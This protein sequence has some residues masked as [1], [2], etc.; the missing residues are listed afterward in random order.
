MPATSSDLRYP[1]SPDARTH[2]AELWQGPRLSSP[3][4]SRLLSTEEDPHVYSMYDSTEQQDLRIS[5][6]PDSQRSDGSVISKHVNAGLASIPLTC[7]K[8]FVIAHGPTARHASSK[9]GYRSC[10]G[11]AVNKKRA[12]ALSATSRRILERTDSAAISRLSCRQTPTKLSEAT[13]DTLSGA[14]S[15][16]TSTS[17][18]TRKPY[19][20]TVDDPQAFPVKSGD[21]A[22]PSIPSASS[23]R[24]RLSKGS[25]VEFLSA[26][27]GTE[28]DS[29]A[30]CSRTGEGTHKSE[31]LA[32]SRLLV[33]LD[34]VQCHGDASCQHAC[35]TTDPSSSHHSS[36]SWHLRSDNSTHGLQGHNALERQ[37]SQPSS[38][39]HRHLSTKGWARDIQPPS[40]SRLH[41]NSPTECSVMPSLAHEAELL[42]KSP[43]LRLP[44]VT[45]HRAQFLSS[46]HV[47][48][49]P[50]RSDTATT[51]DQYASSLD[52]RS[53]CDPAI[54]NS[55][56]P[57]SAHSPRL[58]Q[59][60]ANPVTVPR[61]SIASGS[62]FNGDKVPRALHV[63]SSYS[64]E[65]PDSSTSNLTLHASTS[66]TVTQ[67]ETRTSA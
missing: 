67:E 3:W 38:S 19:A 8:P 15:M 18:P 43:P 30:G 9:Y 48:D 7:G 57:V 47:E 50:T 62:K 2:K 36:N 63:K 66:S 17:S 13:S 64:A 22:A 12:S 6:P 10:H 26:I 11:F 4:D 27:L 59:A 21:S 61:P 54:N 52:T 20:S 41:D 23:L 51:N 55:G 53:C 32:L 40:P 46:L 45:V 44:P 56:T 39:N 1:R 24:L 25:A 58:C 14:C 33:Q 60:S 31:R 65:C 42:T 35:K 49:Y 16:Q 28:R 29:D 37:D 34:E 5:S